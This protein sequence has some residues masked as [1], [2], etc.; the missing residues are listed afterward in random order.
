MDLAF[1]YFFTAGAGVG[2]GVA[3]TIFPTWMLK[4]KLEN[5]GFRKWRGKRK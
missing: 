4:N 2:L 3:V 5:G 1:Q